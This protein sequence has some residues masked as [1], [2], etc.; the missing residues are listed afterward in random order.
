MI[1][2]WNGI[3]A[4]NVNAKLTAREVRSIRANRDGFTNVQLALVYGVSPGH[5][6]EI[7]RGLVRNVH[8]NSKLTPAMAEEIR[9]R[10]E[11]GE[12]QWKLAREFR[13]SDATV[14]LVVRNL[15]WCPDA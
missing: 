2:K 10:R 9:R 11:S 4:A 13:V 15:I 7:R 8:G 3:G 14:S 12:P 6:S 5:I 1:K